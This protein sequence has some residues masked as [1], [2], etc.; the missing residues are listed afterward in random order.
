MSSPKPA[1]RTE[2][3]FT[4]P[5]SLSHTRRCALLRKEPLSPPRGRDG[6]VEDN[7]AVPAFCGGMRGA[8]CSGHQRVSS[9]ASVHRYA[10][11]L[12]LKTRGA[13]DNGSRRE[14]AE[15]AGTSVRRVHRDYGR[16]WAGRLT[17]KVQ[18][19]PGMYAMNALPG[20]YVNLK[21]RLPPAQLQRATRARATFGL[22]GLGCRI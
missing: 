12:C 19:D 2:R 17:C 14:G 20:V 11:A 22:Q 5:R 8:V 6:D 9:C 1:T 16:A 7:A 3:V 10:W 18:T 21:S 4:S 15:P 13:D